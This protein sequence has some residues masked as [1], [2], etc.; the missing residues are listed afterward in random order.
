MDRTLPEAVVFDFDGLILD[1]E[2]PIFEAYRTALSA[3][4]HDLS[5][6]A[7]ARVVGL[8]DADGW[9]ALCDVVGEDL[10]RAEVES[11]Y[12]AQDRS[13]RDRLPPLPG[14]VELLDALGEVDVPFAVASSSPA[15]WIEGH[16]DRLGLLDRFGAI[17]SVDRVD[18]RAK[19]QPDVY[20]LAC[21]DL[22]VDPG[23][24][25]ALEDSATGTL[26]ALAAGLAVVVVPSAITVHHD[27]SRA[28][29]VVPSLTEVDLVLLSDLVG[30]DATG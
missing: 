12:E 9:T 8:G 27:H 2:T 5:V 20:R 24:S 16:L 22:G 17:A 14:V 29:R 4:G 6:E 26:A 21:R 3:M 19:P 1:T 28:H 13:W 18:G 25:V 10:D 15:A 7:W 23:R 11:H 30:R